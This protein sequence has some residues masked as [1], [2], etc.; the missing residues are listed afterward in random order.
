MDE[1]SHVAFRITWDG[2]LAELQT[3]ISVACS[4]ESEDV[5][6]YPLIFSKLES[7]SP[8]VSLEDVLILEK[9]TLKAFDKMKRDT[10]STGMQDIG[11]RLRDHRFHGVLKNKAAPA[12]TVD[13]LCPAQPSKGVSTAGPTM[14][15]LTTR[16]VADLFARSRCSHTHLLNAYV[17]GNL[18]SVMALLA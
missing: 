6:L 14:L 3:E 10:T 15:G 1:V 7:E 16:V 12:T 9:Y 18:N 13:G 2:K 11:S 17:F 4:S 8:A 5:S